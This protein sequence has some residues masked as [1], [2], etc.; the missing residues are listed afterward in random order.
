MTNGNLA[1]SRLRGI[2]LNELTTA[3]LNSV[4]GVSS[5]SPSTAEQLGEAALIADA[6]DSSRT[7]AYGLPVPELGAVQPSPPFAE[8]AHL[9]QP[10]GTELWAIMGIQIVADGGTDTVV[11]SL[12][13]GSVS[14]VIH[15]G[16]TSTT[17][18]SFF[19]WESPL[20]ISNALYLEIENSGV[21][22]FTCAVA[23]HKVGM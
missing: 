2:R 9:V 3:Q 18:Q 1:L 12:T 10:N 20:I 15:S 16:A 22:N 11:I 21:N 8:S 6:L 19:P 14:C 5:I 17:A 23:Y 7:Y 13:D 4:L